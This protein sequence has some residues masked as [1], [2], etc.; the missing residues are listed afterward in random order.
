[1]SSWYVLFHWHDG[2]ESYPAFLSPV[3]PAETREEAYRLAADVLERHRP[4]PHYT[5]HFKHAYTIGQPAAQQ[6]S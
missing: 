4:A 3:G 6:Q 2:Q 5:Y 1:M